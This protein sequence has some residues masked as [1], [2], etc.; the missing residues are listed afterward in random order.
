MTDYEI[1]NK[2]IELAKKCNSRHDQIIAENIIVEFA[3]WFDL[4]K[5]ETNLETDKYKYCNHHH[6]LDSKHELVDFNTGEFVANKKAIP[7]LKALNEIG[8]ETR[9]HHVGE[10]PHAFVSIILD[11]V[12]IEIR[13]VFENDA[14]RTKYNGKKELIIN[15]LL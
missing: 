11:N 10:E 9:T 13:T 1:R 2:A 6:E 5:D 4:K 15:W 8:L 12:D 14:V 7:L 3:K